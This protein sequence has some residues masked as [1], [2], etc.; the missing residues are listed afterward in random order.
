MLRPNSL[1]YLCRLNHAPEQTLADIVERRECNDE[2]DWIAADHERARLIA[3]L[4]VVAVEENLDDQLVTIASLDLVLRTL[5][6]RG[7][8]TAPITSGPVEV[9]QA[10]TRRYAFDHCFGSEFETCGAGDGVY[11]G[12][13]TRHL[14]SSGKLDCLLGL[15]H[16]AHIVLDDRVPPS[17]TANS[18]AAL[19]QSVGIPIGINCS[20]HVTGLV[21]HDVRGYDLAA[22]LPLILPEPRYVPSLGA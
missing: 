19:F 12:L 11:T 17:A 9:A 2:I 10:V 14:G 15:C 1:E 21:Q 3:G 20:K 18:D 4:P 8:L 6:N 5:R 13:I 16:A 22:I 7:L